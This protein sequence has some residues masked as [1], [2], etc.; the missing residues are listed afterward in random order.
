MKI[1]ILA[2]SLKGGGAEA[3]MALLS[4]HFN[5]RGHE[6]TFLG[7]NVSSEH[8]EPSSP[9]EVTLGRHPDSGIIETLQFGFRLRQ[10][11]KERAP[12]IALVNCE[13]A[14]L[15]SLFLPKLR[16]YV[17]EHTSRPWQGRRTLGIVVRFLLLMRRVNWITVNRDQRRS[18]PFR[19][20]CL[21]IPNPIL[22]RAPEL[23][24]NFDVAFVGRLNKLKHPEMIVRLGCDLSLRTVLVGDGPL[25]HELRQDAKLGQVELTGFLDDPWRKIGRDDLVVFPSDYEGDGRTVAEA[26]IR[27]NPVLLRDNPDLRRFNLAEDSYF[28]SYEILKRKTE[29][30]RA[31]GPEIYRPSSSVKKRLEEERAPDSV[32]ERWLQLLSHASSTL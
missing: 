28:S 10:I 21:F 26:I 23:E 13:I 30:Y 5:S 31:N 11:C 12:T 16:L 8:D 9:H 19:Q 2:P 15:F 17:I 29:D 32:G 4:S 27:G 25:L 22:K 6:T 7:I 24:K 14:E 3:S 18:W 1:L 20:R